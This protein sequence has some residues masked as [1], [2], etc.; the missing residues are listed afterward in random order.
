MDRLAPVINRKM[1]RKA[2]PRGCVRE[3]AGAPFYLIFCPAQASFGVTHSRKWRK[4]WRERRRPRVS[5]PLQGRFDLVLLSRRACRSSQR[6]HHR[7]VA[8]FN[9]YIGPL[10]RE[11]C[12]E[13]HSHESGKA[14]GGLCLIHEMAGSKGANMDPQ[15]SRENL[16]KAFSCGRSATPILILKCRPKP[17]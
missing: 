16:T 2:R 4:S 9:D 10:L 11:H 17:G 5:P 13:C 1:R 14:K 7:A 12:Y 8:L 15:S 3:N 6:K